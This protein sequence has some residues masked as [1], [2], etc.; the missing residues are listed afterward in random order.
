M[1][2]LAVEQQRHGL[3]AAVRMP[4]DAARF[5]GR[6][7]VRR[8]GVVEQQEGGELGMALVVEHGMD[9]EAVADPVPLGLAVD[10]Q[11]VFHDCSMATLGIGI[12]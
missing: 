1:V 6:R 8:A 7:E 2:D 12:K 4:V 10:A 3:E 11:D 9:R 5:L